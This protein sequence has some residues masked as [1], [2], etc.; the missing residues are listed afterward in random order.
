MRVIFNEDNNHYWYSRFHRNMPVNE[1]TLR[2]FI[3]QYAN[4]D[5]TDFSLN[6]NASVS[7]TESLVMQDYIQK[8]MA[9]SENGV[10]V[11]YTNT[12]A[13]LLYDLKMRG[14]DPYAIWIDEIKKCGMR[15]LLN[16][17]MNDCHAFIGCKASLVKSEMIEKHPEYYICTG[18]EPTGYF[19]KCLNYLLPYVRSYFLSYITEQLKRYNANGS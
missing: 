17:R 8:Y 3:K 15:G 10:T 16:F 6:V 12:Y 5:I 11:D 18:R 13:K 19:D 2:L 7:S 1:R 9:D 4:T 14:I